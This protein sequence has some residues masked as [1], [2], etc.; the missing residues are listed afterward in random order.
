MERS[1]YLM[2]FR[3]LLLFAWCWYSGAFHRFTWN[4]K[5]GKINNKQNAYKKS[6]FI[7]R[8][9]NILRFYIPI[10]FLQLKRNRTRFKFYYCGKRKKTH[11]IFN[12][13]WTWYF[14]NPSLNLHWMYWY[15]FNA[16]A[17]DSWWLIQFNSCIKSLIRLKTTFQLNNNI[18][19]KSRTMN[20]KFVSNGKNLEVFKFKYRFINCVA[21][22]EKRKKVVANFLLKNK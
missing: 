1:I 8:N 17:F 5:L 12:W 15:W 9:R 10:L 14:W 2:P 16:S 3:I 20:S 6:F 18:Q 21:C 13:S 19:T 11:F 7:E 22:W 4:W